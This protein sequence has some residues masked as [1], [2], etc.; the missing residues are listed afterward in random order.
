MG[1][2]TIMNLR[3]LTQVLN[4]LAP[5]SQWTLTGEDTSDLVWIKKVG[6]I[7]TNDEIIAEVE[8]RQA[9]VEFTAYQRLR[10]SEYPPL[11]DLADA[12]YWQ[13]QGDDSKMQA[14]LAAVQAVK[15]KYPKPEVNE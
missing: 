8:K 7:P 12:M 14:Y 9:E 4:D 2:Y 13:S 10:K 11:A 15:D 5:D 1:D 3:I 6:V